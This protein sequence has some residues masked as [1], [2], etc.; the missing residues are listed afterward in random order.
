MIDE[1]FPGPVGI[2]NAAFQ[3]GDQR[4][5]GDVG[6]GLTVGGQQR[7][8][9]EGG[10]RVR[11][12]VEQRLEVGRDFPRILDGRI[13]QRSPAG[14]DRTRLLHGRGLD[15]AEQG[16]PEH[17]DIVAD[18]VI[19]AGKRV[20][21]RQ[22]QDQVVE[23][24]RLRQRA[25]VVDQVIAAVGAPGVEVRNAS[26]R[27]ERVGER[28]AIGIGVDGGEARNGRVGA[29]EHEPVIGLVGRIVEIDAGIFD[30]ELRPVSGG[31]VGPQIAVPAAVAA[32][33]GFARIDRHR[34][35]HVAAAI[36]EIGTH[37]ARQLVFEAVAFLGDADLA[38]QFEAFEVPADDEVGDTGHGVGAV[39][40][41]SAA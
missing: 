27:G 18:L 31:R 26:A 36:V 39:G 40:C 21:A 35:R 13:D 30:E 15:L 29:G 37:D 22:R 33:A 34:Q 28:A 14:E 19:A 16:L 3:A 20:V 2:R 23:Q 25:A 8:Q 1:G 10:I 6:E 11:T 32:E 7:V 24:A 5:G 4:I 41:R 17:A 12:A 38:V 9:G